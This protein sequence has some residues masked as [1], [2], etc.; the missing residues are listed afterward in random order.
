MFLISTR[1][2]CL[3]LSISLTRELFIDFRL[4]CA[5]DWHEATELHYFFLK[6]FGRRCIYSCSVVFVEKWK[7]HHHLS[8]VQSL[9][10]PNQNFYLVFLWLF[11]FRDHNTVVVP[12]IRHYIIFLACGPLKSIGHVTK[13]ARILPCVHIEP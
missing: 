13:I 7:W 4:I 12:W 6:S 8:S 10:S 1:P 11:I 3:G 9:K 2:T 5:D